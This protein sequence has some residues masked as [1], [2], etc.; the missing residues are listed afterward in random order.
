MRRRE[1]IGLGNGSTERCATGICPDHHAIGRLVI[2]AV[3]TPK[4]ARVIY[5]TARSIAVTAAGAGRLG[6][7]RYADK[8][9]LWLDGIATA[10]AHF[11]PGCQIRPWKR[12]WRRRCRQM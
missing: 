1:F 6:V 11:I 3:V 7:L 12:S 4:K 2:R 10:A 8:T 5:I 9:T